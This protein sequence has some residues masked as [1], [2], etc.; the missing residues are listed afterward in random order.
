MPGKL[1]DK[2]KRFC[3]EYLIDFNATQAAIRAGY[4]EKT[5][6]VIGAENLSKPSIKEYLDKKR[7]KLEEKSE[8]SQEWVLK[9]Y[10]R[11]YD[12]CMQDEAVLDHEGNETGEYKFQSS[13]A[14]KSLDSIRDTLGYKAKE[15]KEVDLNVIVQTGV[16]SP[17]ANN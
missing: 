16:I 17:D 11:V 6:K 14:V 10:Q 9:Q 3:D 2:M 1:T 7:A 13:S 8:I 5:A 12:K 15:K 4:S